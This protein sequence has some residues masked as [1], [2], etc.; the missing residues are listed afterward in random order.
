MACG[1]QT[2]NRTSTQVSMQVVWLIDTL[3]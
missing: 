1:T 2:G 3:Y